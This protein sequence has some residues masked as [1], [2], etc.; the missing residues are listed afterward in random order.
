MGREQ[1]G[2]GLYAGCGSGADVAIGRREAEKEIEMVDWTDE[3]LKEA[4]K[5]F[6]GDY[7]A[8][9]MQVDMRAALDAAV[10]AM[11]I[12]LNP[13]KPLPTKWFTDDYVDA[14]VSKARAEALEE[15][16]AYMEKT[17]PHLSLQEYADA[18]RA[19]KDKP[20]NQTDG[21]E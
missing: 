3:A 8:P 18:I 12:D 7:Y 11:A 21:G 16:A 14:A 5:T 6:M 20:A 2:V 13:V 4:V 9:H 10:K 1:N 15:A 17:L 19:L